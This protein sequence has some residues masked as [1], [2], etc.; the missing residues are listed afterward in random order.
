MACTVTISACPN[1]TNLVGQTFALTEHW[2]GQ[3]GGQATVDGVP[4]SA[5]YTEGNEMSED[6]FECA[7]GD[8]GGAGT[9]ASGDDAE[10]VHT[11]VYETLDGCVLLLTRDIVSSDRTLL[12][13]QHRFRANVSVDFWDQNRLAIKA[14]ATSSPSGSTILTFVP[15][16]V[17][18]V[19]FT[20]NAGLDYWQLVDLRSPPG[21]WVEV[22]IQL[23]TELTPGNFE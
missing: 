3:W 6:T 12:V 8:A 17:Y 7:L 22:P 9:L 15:R 13:T 2:A 11:R 16:G 21:Q 10:T 18:D 23:P 20:D 19:H 1:N 14:T 5:T 4:V